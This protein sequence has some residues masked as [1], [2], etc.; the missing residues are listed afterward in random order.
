MGYTDLLGTVYEAPSIATG[1]GA[2]L[3]QPLLRRALDANPAMSEDEAVALIKKCL[4]VLYYR[5][6]RSLDKVR[7]ARVNAQGCLISDP[8]QLE[9]DWSLALFNPPRQ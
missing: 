1:F 5:D 6:A 7:L 8:I 3:A 9:S 4:Q 2:Y